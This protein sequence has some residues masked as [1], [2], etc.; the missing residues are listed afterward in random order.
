MRHT[1]Y[2]SP[3]G[4]KVGTDVWIC[5]NNNG[6]LSINGVYWSS[7]TSDPVIEASGGDLELF[8]SVDG[9]DLSLLKAKVGVQSDMELI[10]F[11]INQFSQ[12]EHSTHTKI[13]EWLE[14]EGIKYSFFTY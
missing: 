8:M 13:R 1:I 12:Y 14:K 2:K 7:G 9:E 3:A 11:I 4:E 5:P 10:Q 6:G